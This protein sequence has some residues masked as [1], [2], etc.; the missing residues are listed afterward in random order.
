MEFERKKSRF[1]SCLYRKHPV[2][3]PISRFQLSYTSITL[4]DVRFTRMA[5][6]GGPELSQNYQYIG[7][8]RKKRGGKYGCGI[9]GENEVR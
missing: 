3:F 7:G 4:F 8:M 6:V 1:Q 9:K 5:L 2:N